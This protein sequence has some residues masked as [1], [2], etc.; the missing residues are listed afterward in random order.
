LSGG[1]GP[2]T[3]KTP[4]KRA[5]Y[6]QKYRRDWEKDVELAGWL[7]QGKTNTEAFCTVCNKAINIGSTGKQIL[8]RH[9]ESAVHLKLSKSAKKQPTLT[10]MSS[11][12]KTSSLE[13]AVKKADIHL[14]AYV[15]EHNISYNAIDHLPKL[16]K[17]I[18]PDSEIAKQIQCGRTK[19]STIVKNVIGKQNELDVR[20][21]LQTKKFS[22]IIDE[23][24]D[25]SCTKHLAIVC[26]YFDD[27]SKR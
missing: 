9:K 10:S 11:F 24:T 20:S 25:R 18:C 21:I 15:A 14:A 27:E 23:S 6:Y 12:K 26:R 13:E 2:S 8:L 1:E 22:I 7:R 4:A 16:I 19:C 5:K 3:S 17:E